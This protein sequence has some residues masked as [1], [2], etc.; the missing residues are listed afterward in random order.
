M[1]PLSLM[2][3]LI[4]GLIIIFVIIALVLRMM[5]RGHVDL[6]M[7]RVQKLN[8]DNLRRELELKRKLDE[9][10]KEYRKKIAEASKD[11]ARIK[12]DEQR[13]AQD[14]RE[15]TLAEANRERTEIL[16]DAK[17]E[18]E[19]FKRTVARSM[20]EKILNRSGEIVKSLLT[21]QL[22][23]EMH[24]HFVNQVLE[25]L[26]KGQKRLEV[27]TDTAEIISAQPLN[28]DQKKRLANLLTD[29]TG[30]KIK[31]RETIDTNH[32]I[33][34]VYIKLGDLIIDGTLQQRLGHILLK[35]KETLRP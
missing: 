27:K 12:E 4:V 29:K 22:T 9:A 33:S 30:K 25:E 8:E 14:M 23:K 16:T 17:D 19:R 26:K 20:E 35:V 2:I 5:L 28:D 13:L 10:E 32:N 18:A 11:A 31:L 24:A 21:D 34:G 6:A 15:K 3:P 1:P 7:K